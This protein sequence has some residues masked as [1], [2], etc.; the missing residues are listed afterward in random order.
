VI[1]EWRLCF[2]GFYAVS[3][4]GRVRREVAG[5]GTRAGKILKTK[6]NGWGGYPTVNLKANGAAKT[7]FV[8]RLVAEAFLGPC[9]D[10]LEVNHKNG[11]KSDPHAENL[12]YITH[13]QNI[14]HAHANGLANTP[15]G[16]R[17]GSAKLTELAVREMRALRAAGMELRPIAQR[18]GIAMGTTSMV[19]N[20]RTWRHVS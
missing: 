1:E 14:H 11:D 13:R 17:A 20:R 9:P 7:A 5:C 18:F 2:G 4:R 6:V 8:H 10:G 16:E 15:R 19:L 12:E 3:N